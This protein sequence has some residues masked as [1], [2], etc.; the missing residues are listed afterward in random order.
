MSTTAV[1]VAPWADRPHLIS[2]LYATAHHCVFTLK[3]ACRRYLDVLLAWH[4]GCMSS[5][6]LRTGSRKIFCAGWQVLSE[7][8]DD[9]TMQATLNRV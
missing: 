7:R 8:Q 6:V 9:I 4:V 2:C 1:V 5:A 3:N